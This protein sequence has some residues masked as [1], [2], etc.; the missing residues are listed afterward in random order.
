M[1][2]NN[3]IICEHGSNALF[4]LIEGSSKQYC[5]SKYFLND[6]LE[7]NQTIASKA[8]AIETVLDTMNTHIN[9]DL[10]CYFV[11]AI[12]KVTIEDNGKYR[13]NNNFLF[14]NF[15]SEDNRSRVI[16]ADGI[17]IILKA[18]DMHT[19]NILVFNSGQLALSHLLQSK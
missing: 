7:A 1:H 2:V 5:A 10:I 12:L 14:S 18:I 16:K 6:I 15:K 4:C 8:N 9:N 13:R 19:D 11:C 3:E 17:G